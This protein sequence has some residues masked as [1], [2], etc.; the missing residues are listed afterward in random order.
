MAATSTR[1]TRIIW[2]RRDLRL[3]DN[4]LYHGAAGAVVPLYVFDPQD[5]APRPSCSSDAPYLVAGVGPFAGRFLLE[6]VQCLRDSLR[7]RGSDLFVRRGVSSEV[8]PAFLKELIAAGLKGP[9]EVVWHDEAGTYEAARAVAVR[10]ALRKLSCDAGSTP[11]VASWSL[12]GATLWHPLDLP[13]Y[14]P[15]SDKEGQEVDV[16]PQSWAAIKQQGVQSFRRKAKA[17]RLRSPHASPAKLPAMP[18]SGVASDEL[19][20][21]KSLI[22]SKAVFGFTAEEVS[23]ILDAAEGEFD[24][25]SA[26]P[27]HGGEDA[28]Q[29]HL[30]AFVSGPAEHCN[31]EG[32]GDAD[33]HID[34][35][36]KVSAYLAFGCLSPRTIHAV[37][38]ARRD[39]KANWL[40]ENMEM[41]DFWIFYA[42][43]HGDALFV[44]DGDGAANLPAS[45]WRAQHEPGLW[46]RWLLGTTGLPLLDAA[47]IEMRSTGYTSNR[48]R[49]IPVSVLANDLRIDW[50]AG[51]ELYQWLLVDHDIGCNWGNW[52]Y[53]AGVGCDP[54]RRHY[55]ALS[56]GLRYDR[57]ASFIKTWLPQLR[58][59]S[60]R[61]AHLIP[62][63]K[64]RSVAADE[65]DWPAAC[66]D[67][68]KQLSWD[69][70]KGLRWLVTGA[71][72]AYEG[73]LVSAAKGRGKGGKGG[74]GKDAKGV[75]TP[76][77]YHDAGHS[78][79]ERSGYQHRDVPDSDRNKGGKSEGKSNGKGKTDKSH[80]AKGLS[81]SALADADARRPPEVKVRRWHA[82]G[83]TVADM[84]MGA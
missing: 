74:K 7:A 5:F 34:S 59:L 52:R 70:Q 54:K 12:W 9:I 81:I 46:R 3:T 42:L 36:A 69:D 75:S 56:Q 29:K 33:G 47:M 31:R 24:S 68:L 48:C 43:A 82:K 80:T 1:P 62:V 79:V 65:V 20:S 63:R 57:D 40:P 61:E 18:V 66:V 6:S 37:C 38:H 16:S 73:D 67:A 55:K 84:A 23:T 58:Q 35:S 78:G 15:A 60:A 19:P 64:A 77:S 41:R 17:C 22:S 11:Q 8:L 10:S 2:H 71:H 13:V 83:H 21:L 26:H 51:A 45:H 76:A 4:L 28:G 30:A 53:F 39:G 32:G 25:R 50:R 44:R 14:N 27:L 72:D 49:Q